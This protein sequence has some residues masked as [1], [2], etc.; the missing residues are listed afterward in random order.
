MKIT[1]DSPKSINLGTFSHFGNFMFSFI[2]NI[3]QA[4]NIDLSSTSSFNF[5][6]LQKKIN[7]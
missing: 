7:A 6:D 5:K 2:V 4:V 3:S 1:L